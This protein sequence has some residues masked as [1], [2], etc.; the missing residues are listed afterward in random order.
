MTS[1][2]SCLPSAIAPTSSA[3]IATKA[4]GSVVARPAT[5]WCS[6]ALHGRRH[7][8]TRQG[9]EGRREQT[10]RRPTTMRRAESHRCS[11]LD[12]GQRRIERDFHVA[13]DQSQARHFGEMAPALSSKR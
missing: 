13:E 1:S 10:G 3:S 9:A 8:A 6:A 7:D 11:L 4:A 5:A 2:K 12:A